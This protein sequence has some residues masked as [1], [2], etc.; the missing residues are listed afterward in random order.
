MKTKM[1][2][3][4]LASLATVTLTFASL[5]VYASG[6]IVSAGGRVRPKIVC[7]THET[8]FD[9][10]RVKELTVIDTQ[11]SD[12]SLP[13]GSDA[14]WSLSYEIKG[15]HMFDSCTESLFRQMPVVETQTGGYIREIPPNAKVL[16]TELIRGQ[17]YND[18]KFEAV[19]RSQDFPCRAKVQTDLPVICEQ[20]YE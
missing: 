14:Q 11:L 18:G 4:A 8:S 17:E 15:S 10:Y 19:L 1:T 5:S 20:M 16:M 7:S 9:R 12:T 3:A 13:T 2:F 6:T